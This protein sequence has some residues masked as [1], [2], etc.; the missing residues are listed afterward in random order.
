MPA[1]SIVSDPGVVKRSRIRGRFWLLKFVSIE[2]RKEATAKE[3]MYILFVDTDGEATLSDRAKLFQ[4][5]GSQAVRLP[6][7]Y[8][9]EGQSEVLI[10]RS[11]RRVILE[12]VEREW[13]DE[14]LKLAGS[15]KDFPYP[16]DPPEA[17]PGPDFGS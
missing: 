12:P 4:S 3:S 13:S 17:E 9:F 6:K 11:G 7:D 16:G 10:Y 5:G 1:R 14:F 8:R 2:K 15:A